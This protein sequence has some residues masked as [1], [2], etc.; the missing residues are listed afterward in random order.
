MKE[1]NSG[2]LFLLWLLILAG[3][4]LM[5]HLGKAYPATQTSA[6]VVQAGQIDP[7]ASLDVQN[8]YNN[9]QQ[10]GF[11]VFLSTPSVNELREGEVVIVSSTTKSIM[12][13]VNDT[14]WNLKAVSN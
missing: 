6:R 10:K 14:L 12:F 2:S 9:F 3:L 1:K 11:K 13:R 5:A 4:T 8:I 7:N